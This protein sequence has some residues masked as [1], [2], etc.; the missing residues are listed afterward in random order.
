LSGG[1][2]HGYGAVK[3]FD[4]NDC[5]LDGAVQRGFSANFWDGSATISEPTYRS[6]IFVAYFEN[7]INCID[8]VDT[9]NGQTFRH[10]EDLASF[11]HG[12]EID[13]S[14]D[15]FDFDA[16]WHRG[17]D[18]IN[19]TNRE[20]DAADDPAALFRFH[21]EIV[22]QNAFGYDH[23][24]VSV[25]GEFADPLADKV[26]RLFDAAVSTDVD[27]TVPERADGEDGNRQKR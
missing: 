14:A 1:N 12:A 9:T 13:I 8:E 18:E 25:M 19:G 24:V 21:V 7:D 27:G 4:T 3:K 5:R 15:A 16:G 26:L 20:I 23:G 22:G 10:P 2:A 17:R 6:A 11:Q